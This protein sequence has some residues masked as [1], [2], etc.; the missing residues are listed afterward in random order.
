MKYLFQQHSLLHNST[1]AEERGTW[2]LVYLFLRIIPTSRTER[3]IT[4]LMNFMNDPRES[5]SL[6]I[7]GITIPVVRMSLLGNLVTDVRAGQPIRYGNRM[8]V[9][10]AAGI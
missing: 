8:C 3:H 6:L 10:C 1:G 4:G 5:T 7:A 9:S 2:R